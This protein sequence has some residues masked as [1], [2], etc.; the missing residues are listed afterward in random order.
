[1]TDFTKKKVLLLGG[2][3]P[4]E[5]FFDMIYHQDIYE[6]WKEFEI[7]YVKRMK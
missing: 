2:R 7:M 5:A 1:M 4:N 6:Y 3:L